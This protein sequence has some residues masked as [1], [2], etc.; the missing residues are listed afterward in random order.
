MSSRRS[1]TPEDRIRAQYKVHRRD[2]HWWH[3]GGGRAGL[4]MS[5]AR[6]WKRP[7]REIKRIVGLATQVEKTD[8]TND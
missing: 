5:L 7:I 4:L 8:Q 3:D 6:Q 1:T 2:R